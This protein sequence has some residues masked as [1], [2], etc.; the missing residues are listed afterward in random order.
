MLNQG[1]IKYALKG[2]LFTWK[3]NGDLGK[4]IL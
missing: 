2:E 4:N 1:R 3:F